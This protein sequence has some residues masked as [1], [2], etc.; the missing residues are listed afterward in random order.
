MSQLNADSAQVEPYIKPRSLILDLFGDYLRYTGSEVKA[1]DL[2]S[3]L[4]V[5]GLEPA[6][7]RVTLSRLRR[8]RWF[9]T[10][11]MGR[12]TI[13]VLSAHMLTVLD[14]G[15]ARIFVDYDEPWDHGWTVVVHVSDKPDRLTREQLR[16]QLAWL[17]FGQLSA[18]TWL[19]PRDRADQARALAEKF[20]E[21]HFTVMRARTGNLDEDRDLAERCWDLKRINE[22]YRQFLADNAHLP[23]TVDALIGTDALVTR[24]SLIARYRH[25]PFLDPWLPTDL[26]PIGWQGAAANALFRSVHRDLGAEA[27]AFVGGV[28]GRPV[29]APVI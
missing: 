5:F 7:V 26:R 17:G 28:V 16:R 19:T 11:R 22:L 15:R 10:R 23:G 9:T 12:E 4:G 3:L 14:D 6:T 1:G 21:V 13:Y 29:D 2:V 24:T 18:S 8:E 25:F 27:N 20:P